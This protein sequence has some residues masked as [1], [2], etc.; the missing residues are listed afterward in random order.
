MTQNDLVLEHLIDGK[1]ITPLDALNLYGCFRL[2]ARVNDLRKQG[3]DIRTEMIKDGRKRYA[4]YFMA[5]KQ[6]QEMLFI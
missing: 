1:S 4:R 5:A 2:G 3:Y 6:I